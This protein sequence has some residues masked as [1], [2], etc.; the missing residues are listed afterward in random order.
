MIDRAIMIDKRGFVK[1][2]TQNSAAGDRDKREMLK[3]ISRL[4]RAQ[5]VFRSN[6]LCTAENTVRL[7]L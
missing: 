7:S 2:K 5:V 3:S 1:G 4:S 6:T